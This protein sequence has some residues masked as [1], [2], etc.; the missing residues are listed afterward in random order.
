MA[1]QRLQA[2]PIPRSGDDG[3]GLN[4]RAVGE[5]DIRPLEALDR[6][7]D[8]DLSALDC[9]AEAVVHRRPHA[10]LADAGDE[11]HRRTGEAPRREVTKRESLARGGHAI[12]DRGRQVIRKDRD[13]VDRYPEPAARD[14]VGRR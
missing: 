6:C 3:I 9:P 7:D 10:P 5:D 2:P 1:D 8:L 13:W 11:T 14:D 12:A 4:T